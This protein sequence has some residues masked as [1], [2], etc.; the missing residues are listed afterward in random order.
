MCVVCEV[1]VC[2]RC[3]VYVVCVVYVCDVCGVLKKRRGRLQDNKTTTS[4][5]LGNSN[6]KTY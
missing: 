5:S 4:Y 1:C 3:V 6:H 2:V